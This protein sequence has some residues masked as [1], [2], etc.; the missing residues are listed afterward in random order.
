[1]TKKGDQWEAEMQVDDSML[2]RKIQFKFVE[3]GS[4]WN[5]SHSLPKIKDRSGNENNFFEISRSGQE[6]STSSKKFSDMRVPRMI[7][8]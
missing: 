1:M 7:L 2:G 4:N 5:L 3:D 6:R 8:N